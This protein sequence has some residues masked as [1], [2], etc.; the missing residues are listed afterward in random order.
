MCAHWDEHVHE[1]IILSIK[2][3]NAFNSKIKVIFM[4]YMQDFGSF[5][6]YAENMQKILVWTWPFEQIP[7]YMYSPIK[8]KVY[9]IYLTLSYKGPICTRW[10]FYL[11]REQKGTL[12]ILCNF[13]FCNNIFSFHY[14]TFTYRDVLLFLFT[15]LK[16]SVTQPLKVGCI[17]QRIEKI[18]VW[19]ILSHIFMIKLHDLAY[20]N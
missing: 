14:Y 13:S 9:H 16:S 11:K 6:K 5:R 2:P 18:C 15:F 20:G 17:R 12:L 19:V 8:Q 4:F 1:Y 7:Y 3:D 10:H